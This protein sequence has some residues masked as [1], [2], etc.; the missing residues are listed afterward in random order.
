MRSSEVL[1]TRSP[2][3]RGS[4]PAPP[5][6]VPPLAPSA[7]RV[8]MGTRGLTRFPAS[9]SAPLMSSQDESPDSPGITELLAHLG[10]GDEREGLLFHLVYQRLMEVATHLFRGERGSHTLQ[11]TALVHE[12]WLKLSRGKSVDWQNRE[13]FFAVGATVMRRILVDYARSKGRVKRGVGVRWTQLDPDQAAPTPPIGD[14]LDIDAALDRLAALDERQARII[15]LRF[16]SGL[17]VP[18]VASCLGVST[19]TIEAEWTVAKAWLR[20]EL[21][22]GD[23]R[24]GA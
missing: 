3:G 4:A 16:F 20:R 9:S 10:R 19:R 18:E 15:E 8:M 21:V 12:A 1:E 22:R 2:L 13:Q 17:T 23:D 24:G 14:I 7:G 11:P 6:L 5:A